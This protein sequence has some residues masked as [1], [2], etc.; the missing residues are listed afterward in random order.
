VITG[1]GRGIGEAV[2]RRLTQAGAR[3][4]LAS[5]TLTQ[6][7]ATAATLRDRGHDVHTEACD[8]S[9]PASVD[10]LARRAA[11]CLGGVD[12]LVNN[13][14]I[15]LSAPIRSTSVE[16]WN[17]LLAV[18]TT[19]SFLCLKAFLPQMIDRGWGRIV[20]VASM[21]GLR[22]DRYIAA[23]AASKHAVV[24]LTTSAAAEAAPHGVTVNA[25]CP[26]YVATDMTRE[27]I[28]RIVSK[29]GRS[30]SEALDE[31]LRT[32]PQRRLIEADEVAAAVEY[33][34]SDAARSVNGAAL[35]I[36]GGE[37]RR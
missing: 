23:Y 1:A 28:A 5:R 20:N 19:G 13:A 34:C 31:I 29:T 12:I 22:G 7:E 14:G 26:G 9:D 8:V 35:V 21:A 3:V 10:R 4:L 16:D 18:N 17:R 37:L 24:G 36:D 32:T 33:L 30:E 25:V 11:E 15:A 6:L 2:A 27:T